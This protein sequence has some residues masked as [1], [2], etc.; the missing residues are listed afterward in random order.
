MSI[1]GDLH[2]ATIISLYLWVVSIGKLNQYQDTHL[3]VKGILSVP[4][5]RGVLNIRLTVTL[6]V[7]W[8]LR[9]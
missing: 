9:A 7:H 6:T 2:R 4:P 8:Y 3:G 5:G 1:Y